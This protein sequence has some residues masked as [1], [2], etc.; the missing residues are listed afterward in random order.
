MI[1]FSHSSFLFYF[2]LVTLFSLTIYFVL[3]R[4]FNSAS[5]QPFSTQLTIFCRQS[6]KDNIYL[7]VYLRALKSNFTG[8]VK[9]IIM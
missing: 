8:L 5:F 2:T 7:F 4:F 3:F 9:T 6:I 1:Q